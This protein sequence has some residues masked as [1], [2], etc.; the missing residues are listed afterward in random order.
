[1]SPLHPVKTLCV[2]L[3][4]VL[5]AAEAV[6]ALTLAWDPSPAAN[7]ITQYRLYERLSTGYTLVAATAP[8]QTRFVLPAL[9]PGVHIYSVTAMDGLLE[10]PRSN[11]LVVSSRFHDFNNTGGVAVVGGRG[12]GGKGTPYPAELN[13]SHVKGVISSVAVLLHGVSDRIASKLDIL[14]VG[15]QGQKVLLMSDVGGNNPV[16]DAELSFSDDAPQSLGTAPIT[17]GVYKPSNRDTSTDKDNFP[18]PAPAKPYAGALSVFRGTDPNGTWK[19]FVLEEGTGRSGGAIARG[20]TLRI[21]TDG[22]PIVIAYMPT[23]VTST[24][25]I[26]NGLINP[27]GK[28]SMF[29]FQYGLTNGSPDW[30]GPPANGRGLT[31]IPAQLSLTGLLPNTVY[32]YRLVA[33]NDFGS[34]ASNEITFLTSP[35]IDSDHDGLPDDYEL[36]Y[37]LNPASTGDAG[38]DSDGDGESNVQ[39][40]LAGTDPLNP[41]SVFRVAGIERSNDVSISF[42]SVLGRRYQIQRSDDLTQ[43]SWTTIQ[44][45]IAGT[46]Q[47]ITIADPSAGALSRAFY[48]AVVLP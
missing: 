22:P 7:G 29:A 15:P 30:Q 28:N 8:H 34:S 26:L 37:H 11:E 24:T 16:S 4:V 14:L 20:W 40:F 27:M 25:A 42:S 36:L 43:P 3:F 35:L 1:M 45:E 6:S 47:P 18:A 33:Q 21:D 46:G 19:L 39:E 10:S 12:S 5:A 44:S 9:S 32:H 31:A 23:S 48:R 38:F 17:S 41:A 13:I 2:V